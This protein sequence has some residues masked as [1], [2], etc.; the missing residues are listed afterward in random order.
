MAT[1]IQARGPDKCEIS[2]QTLTSWTFSVTKAD[3]CGISPLKR[4]AILNIKQT[5]SIS[6]RHFLTRSAYEPS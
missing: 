5:S 4:R 1:L 2:L 6:D 3:L